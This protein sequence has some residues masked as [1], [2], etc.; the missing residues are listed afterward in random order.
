ML[1]KVQAYRKTN[2]LDQKRKF[3]QHII[4]HRRK[5]LKAARG[6]KCNPLF[7][8]PP[9]LLPGLPLP[10]PPMIPLNAGLKHPYPGLPSFNAS[11]GLWPTDHLLSPNEAS[12]TGI[13]VYLMNC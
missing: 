5:N 8:P 7:P 12:S 4:K 3:P 2:R 6:E 13:V 10:P 9:L 1:I 11:Y